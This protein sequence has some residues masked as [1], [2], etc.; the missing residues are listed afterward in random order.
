MD[1]SRGSLIDN[2]AALE[3][4]IERPIT[5]SEVKEIME[6]TMRQLINELDIRIAQK[7]KTSLVATTGNVEDDR[8]L[9]SV[10]KR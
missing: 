1:S 9:A 3:P 6:S 8:N 4:A 7:T 2:R 5:R 10:R